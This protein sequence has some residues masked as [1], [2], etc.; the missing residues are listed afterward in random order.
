M[1]VAERM[2]LIRMVEKMN[3]NKKFS[4]KLGIRNVSLFKE[5]KHKNR[6]LLMI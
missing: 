4:Q 3:D 2:R 5:S 1:N 6:D